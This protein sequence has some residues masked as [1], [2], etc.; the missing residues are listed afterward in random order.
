MTKKAFDQ[1]VVNAFSNGMFTGNPA[2]VVPLDEWLPN[3]YLQSIAEQNN[4]A[5]TAFYV[6]QGDGDYHI[7]WF[8][9]AVE[10]DLC[11]HAT[12]ASAFVV[13]HREGVEELC[14][15]SRSGPLQVSLE[16]GWWLMDFPS[17]MT[18]QV[19]PPA[20]LLK[21]M[22][23]EHAECHFNEDYV[24]VLEN[25]QSVVDL[26]VHFESLL[27]L[28]GRGV[29]VTAE[30]QHYDFVHRFFGPKVGVN[31]DSVTGSALTKLIPY[32]AQRLDKTILTAKQVSKRGGEIKCHFKGERVG[33]AG[34]ADLFAKGQI[35]F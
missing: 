16:N 1:Y 11:G 27:T 14:F 19:E 25:A 29:I 35:Y 21:A 20:Q 30:S 23:L 28:N 7:R 34:R 26:N 13:N 22:Q 17:Q 31:E 4:L 2:A 32:W 5:E 15:H 8:T 10:V 12:L 33:I 9:P 6:K 24:V 18:E 3:K